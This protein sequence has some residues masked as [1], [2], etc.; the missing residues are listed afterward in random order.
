MTAAI[1]ALSAS[2]AQSA[3]MFDPAIDRS[4]EEWC[5]A[6]QSTTVIGMPFVS[7]PVQVTYDGAIYTR[8]AELAFFS[9]ETLKPV[10]AR[11]KTFLDGWIPVVCYGW[12]D[13][14]VDYRLELFSAELPELGRTNLVQFAQL[15]MTNSGPSPTVGVVAAAIRGSAGHFR[16]GKVR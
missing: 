12:N 5:Y 3:P 13:E 16:L 9:G 1:V 14:G 2:V 7:E 11:G 15:T 10:M 6:A 4:D 8:H